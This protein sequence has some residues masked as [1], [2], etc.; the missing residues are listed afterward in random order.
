MAARGN[1]LDDEVKT[2][3]KTEVKHEIK[4]NPTSDEIDDSH[5][6]NT[7]EILHDTTGLNTLMAMPERTYVGDGAHIY[8]DDDVLLVSER[9]RD[10]GAPMPPVAFFQQILPPPPENF[11]GFV[12]HPANN[13]SATD[14]LASTTIAT[15]TNATV[16]HRPDADDSLKA[17]PHSEPAAAHWPHHHSSAFL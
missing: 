8:G 13:R 15:V 2:E 16:S 10:R 17:L 9:Q 5:I 4:Q 7:A 6:S 11:Y 12:D 3:V 1:D 14:H